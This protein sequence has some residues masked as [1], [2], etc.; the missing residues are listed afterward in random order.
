MN[1]R[2]EFLIKSA[3]GV[4]GL[5]TVPSWLHGAP[6][7][8]K[9]YNKPN[10]NINGVKIGCITYSFRSRPDQS[11]EANIQYIKDAGIS[12]VEMMGEPVEYFAGMPA[13]TFD[14][15]RGFQL[16][17]KQRSG[18]DLTA[19]EQA[20][21]K[22]LRGQMDAYGQVVANWRANVDLKKFEQAKKLF[23][24]AGIEVYAFKPNAFGA[25]NSDAEVTYGMKAAKILGASHVTLEHPSDDAQT[26]RLGKLADASKMKV[27]YHGHEQ[28]TFTFWDKAIEQSKGNG[29]NFDIGHYI[30]AGHT[31][32]MDL[33]AK[34]NERIWS[35]HIK[36]RQTPENGKGNLPWGQG[37]TPL[38]EALTAMRDKKYKFPATIE[39]EYDVPQGSDAVK[40]VQKCLEYCRMALS[41]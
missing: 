26:L 1:K 11:L 23:K 38:K 37:D 14:R 30:A 21:W 3:L 25:N 4:G 20:E 39:L 41:K 33:I 19:D 12:A 8:I 6:A 34:Q 29:L 13:P 35:M 15:R 17:W 28:Q 22:E 40:E 32:A 5:I 31:D 36:D 9:T 7:I 24:G 16:G 10:S 27:G 2:R 18:E